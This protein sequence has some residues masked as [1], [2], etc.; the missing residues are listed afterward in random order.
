[1]KEI[2]SIV[3]GVFAGLAT[4]FVLLLATVPKN[5]DTGPGL[6]IGMMLIFGIIPLFFITLIARL[7]SL[8]RWS[9]PWW[10]SSL[11]GAVLTSAAFST[12]VL[13][14]G[15]GQALGLQVLAAGLVGGSV[16]GGLATVLAGGL[17]RPA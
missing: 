15:Y 12:F 16:A 3:A 9:K 6:T 14:M 11:T 17:A 5:V 7:V 8:A 4:F 13:H 2:L 10:A 1:V